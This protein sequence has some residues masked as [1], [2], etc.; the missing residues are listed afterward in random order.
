MNKLLETLT[1]GARRPRG[2]GRARRSTTSPPSPRAWPRRDE[3]IGRLVANLDTVTATLDR[4]DAQIDAMVQNLIDLTETFGD[5][6]DTLDAALTELG[7]SA[8]T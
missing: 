1:R 5:N 3:A 7:R 8:P 6:T 2:Q 4:R